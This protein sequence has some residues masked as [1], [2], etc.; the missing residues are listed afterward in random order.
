M[1]PIGAA[2]GQYL[3]LLPLVIIWIVGIVI[4][5]TS[6]RKHP[7]ISLYAVIGLGLLLLRGLFVTGANVWLPISMYERGMA[8]GRIGVITTMVGVLSALVASVGWVLILLAIFRYR[9][10]RPV[11][12][13]TD[14]EVV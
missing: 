7:Q 6:W 13:V 4:A 5:I 1:Q 2:L 8:V 11:R 3:L 12:G 14:E 10:D 9:T